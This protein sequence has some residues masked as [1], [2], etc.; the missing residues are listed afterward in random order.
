MER[1]KSLKR[2]LAYLRK[3]FRPDGPFGT[4]SDEVR[5][6]LKFVSQTANRRHDIAHLNLA[7]ITEVENDYLLEMYS[8]EGRSITVTV[9]QLNGLLSDIYEGVYPLDT[10]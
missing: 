6:V 3:A 9:S 2:K 10:G 4:I 1:P 5:N 8:L 7:S